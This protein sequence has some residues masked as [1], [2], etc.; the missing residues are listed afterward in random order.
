MLHRMTGGGTF[1]I[2]E[3]DWQFYWRRG[4]SATLH[5]PFAAYSEAESLAIK[6][7]MT[8]QDRVFA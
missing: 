6:S 2:K 8:C 5:G 1:E 4:D 3:R 7:L